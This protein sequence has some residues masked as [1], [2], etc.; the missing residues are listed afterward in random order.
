MGNSLHKIVGRSPFST[1]TASDVWPL[2][3]QVAGV[4]LELEGLSEDAQDTL[5]EATEGYWSVHGDGSLRNGGIEFVLISPMMGKELSEAISVFFRSN[6]RLGTPSSRASTHVH[7]NM[8]QPEDTIEVL[9]NLCSFYYAIEDA[10]YTCISESRKWAV[11]ASPMSSNF[12]YEVAMLFSEELDRNLWLRYL[13][14]TGKTDY[15]N[16]RH[17]GFNLKAMRKYGTVEFRHFPAVT[18]EQELRDWINLCMEIKKVASILDDKKTTTKAFFSTVESFDALT[19]LMP[20]WGTRI[21]N[22]LNRKDSIQKIESL[23]ELLPTS[24][25]YTGNMGSYEDHDL[26]KESDKVPKS[27]RPAK[28][29]KEL[30]DGFGEAVLRSW[31]EPQE[32]GGWEEQAQVAPLATPTGRTSRRTNA[33][34]INWGQI[35]ARADAAL[36]RMRGMGE[37]EVNVVA[38]GT[39]GEINTMPI[40]MLTRPLTVGERTAINSIPANIWTEARRRTSTRTG[41]TPTERGLSILNTARRMMA[42]APT[43]A[44]SAGIRFE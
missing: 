3:M 4:E 29:Q 8:L 9:R 21:L 39:L 31:D 17:Y 26:F 41:E 22:Q 33:A 25:K 20:I 7:L 32:V 6:V 18:S 34:P 2:P 12:P 16:G 27:K 37:A 30:I 40:G 43:P 42:N 1:F 13:E 19:D 23:Y 24:Q 44:R 10:L 11:Y 15:N 38:Q 36:D 5:T 14:Q 35:Q 28:A